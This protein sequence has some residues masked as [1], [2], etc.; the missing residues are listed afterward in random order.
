MRPASAVCA[1]HPAA[2]SFVVP[3]FLS[4]PI[5]WLTAFYDLFES[6][7]VVYQARK[8]LPA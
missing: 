2:V 5:L 1:N 4:A 8:A 7:R 3:G 6:R